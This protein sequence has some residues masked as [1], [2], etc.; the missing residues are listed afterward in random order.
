MLIEP[1]T[2]QLCISLSSVGAK[3]VSARRPRVVRA[4][5]VLSDYDAEYVYRL[6]D[7]WLAKRAQYMIRGNSCYNAPTC[8]PGIYRNHA[9]QSKVRK[10]KCNQA[11]WL[12]FLL[13]AAQLLFLVDISPYPWVFVAIL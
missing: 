5:D 7:T 8:S 1:Y 6:Y 3:C 11:C 12:L 13:G 2:R 9:D 10:S 4:V